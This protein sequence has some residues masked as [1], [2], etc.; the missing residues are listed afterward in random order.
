LNEFIKYLH[1]NHTGD[2]DATRIVARNCRESAKVDDDDNCRQI[3]Q[4]QADDNQVPI[5]VDCDE[6]VNLDMSMDDMERP[7]VI[8]EPPAPDGDTVAGWTR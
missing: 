1:R 2:L 7:L 8:V 5:L 4:N 3:V 6:N